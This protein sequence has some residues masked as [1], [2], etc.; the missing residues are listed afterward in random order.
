MSL[1]PS[2]GCDL[3]IGVGKFV[4][5]EQHGL[6]RQLGERVGET[7]AKIQP[8]RVTTTVIVARLGWDAK[9]KLD[10]ILKDLAIE[11]VPFTRDQA[12]V[13]ILAYRQYG[14]NHQPK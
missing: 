2:L 1:S 11:V 5:F 4:A 7:V 3:Q 12:E 6:V 9:E 8:R 10:R 13:A 14:N